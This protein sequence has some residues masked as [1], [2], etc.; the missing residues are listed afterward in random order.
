MISFDRPGYG[1]SD[2][3]RG[4]SVAN[5][6]SDEAAGADAPGLDRFAVTGALGGGPHA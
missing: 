3:K 6:A 4:R 5:C 2:R 1:G